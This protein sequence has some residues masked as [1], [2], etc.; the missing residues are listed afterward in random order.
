MIKSSDV[1]IVQGLKNNNQR[2]INEVYKRY[3]K[4]IKQFIV[5]N[6]GDEE[7]AKDIFQEA[8]MIVF[9]NCRNNTLELKCS[10]KTY[11]YSIARNQWYKK[12]RSESSMPEFVDSHNHTEI[13]E[14]IIDDLDPDVI[15]WSERRTF[16][17]KM[18][19]Q[20]TK[21]C[22]KILKMV[23]EGLDL[24]VITKKMKHNSVQHTKN[25]RYRCKEQLITKMRNSPHYIKLKNENY[26]A[27]Y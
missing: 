16:F 24:N 4:T 3:F 13:L 11:L 25:R 2:A 27:N 14:S 23:L 5:M 12:S 7:D 15:K 10:L 6:H 22:Q 17:Y 21:D 26:S 19:S 1:D 18:F 8:M 9:E 20:L